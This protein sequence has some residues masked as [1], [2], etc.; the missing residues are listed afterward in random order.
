MEK[1]TFD[2]FNETY[3]VRRNQIKQVSLYENHMFDQDEEEC[4]YLENHD[5]N[6]IWTILVQKEGKVLSP[7]LHY[8]DVLGY[9]IC[10]NIW[11]PK[12]N[13]FILI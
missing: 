4:D 2:Q 9:F 13:N 10:K 3:E 1:I 7:G 11:Q 5:Q 8:H 6:R 12:Q